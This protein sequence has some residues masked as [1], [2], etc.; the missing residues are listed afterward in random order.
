MEIHAT[1]MQIVSTEMDRSLV[2]A[3][4]DSQGT[5]QFAMVSYRERSFAYG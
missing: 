4:V 2:L 1:A 3:R 5:E